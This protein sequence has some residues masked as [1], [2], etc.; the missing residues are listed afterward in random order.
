MNVIF[1]WF[2]IKPKNAQGT[3]YRSMKN[4]NL[5]IVSYTFNSSTLEA[6]AGEFLNFEATY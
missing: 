3:I 4:L 2:I 5:G 1:I 6:E